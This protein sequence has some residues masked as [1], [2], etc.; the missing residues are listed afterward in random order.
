RT[1]VLAVLV[2]VCMALSG[3]PR[4]PS[5]AGPAEWIAFCAS[6]LA[7]DR[8]KDHFEGF[9][10]SLTAMGVVAVLS[11]VVYPLHVF[12][13][14]KK[15]AVAPSGQFCTRRFVTLGLPAAAVWSFAVWAKSRYVW[16]LASAL[17]FALYCACV[18]LKITSFTGTVAYLRD[19]EE[20]L[21]ATPT[22][23]GKPIT[24]GAGAAAAAAAVDNNPASTGSWSRREGLPA[25][26]LTFREYLFFL[27]L[28]PSLVCEVRLMKESA[29][30]PSRPVRAA[31]EFFHAV[32]TFLVAHCMVGAVVAPSMRV[33]MTGFRPQWVEG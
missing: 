9:A 20:A 21:A 3:V 4:P 32:F 14:T 15:A 16:G 19:E 27:F 7:V 6:A 23:N 28:A 33:F 10:T 22:L 18:T 2:A 12:M 31:S 30:W 17:W 25:H 24:A 8:L 5:G 1:A 11:I 13:T 26:P 29:R